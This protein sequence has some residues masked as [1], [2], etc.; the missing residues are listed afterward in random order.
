MSEEIKSHVDVREGVVSIRFRKPI[1]VA[2]D[3]VVAGA[4]GYLREAARDPGGQLIRLTLARKVTVNSM[5]AGEHLFIDLL[6][7]TWSGLPPGLP[8]QIIAELAQRARDI[9]KKARHLRHQ[10]AT[11]GQGTLADIDAP[12]TMPAQVFGPARSR[13]AAENRPGVGKPVVAEIRREGDV[14][15]LVFPFATPTPAAAFR[16]G[17]ALWLIFDTAAPID[18]KALDADIGGAAPIA[19]RGAQAMRLKLDPKRP[20][21]LAA[22]GAG[23]VVTIGGSGEPP[24]ALGVR[25]NDAG[26]PRVHI[27]F[28]EPKRVHRIADPEIGDTVL[29]VTALGPV[30]GLPKA[31]DFVE[32]RA[33]ATV[34]GIAVQSLADDVSDRACRGRELRSTG[35]AA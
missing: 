20:V 26:A 15:R 25:R 35:R 29:A 34:H 31:Q 33:L 12:P 21:S 1:D 8:P 18:L 23:W 11:P 9:E 7:A 30:R 6:P 28:A 3:G 4:A 17:D 13:D 22:A 16:R 24:R 10:S 14:R 19:M 32:F 5:A 2:L 27:P